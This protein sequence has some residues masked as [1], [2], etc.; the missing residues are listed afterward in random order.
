[1]TE[2]MN[3]K[4]V[5]TGAA[6]FIGSNVARALNA[7]GYK[8]LILVDRSF[9][10]EK[11]KNISDLIYSQKLT[12]DEFSNLTKSD[13]VRLEAII[14]IGASVDTT[15]KD[16]AGLIKNNTEYSRV[17]FDYCV[18]NNSRLIY[19]SSAATYGGGEKGYDDRERNLK[20][21]NPYAESKYLFDEYAQ[22]ALQKPAQWVGLKF[23]NVYGPGEA[24]KG[25][26]ASMVYHLY[27]K[28]KATGEAQIFKSYRPGIAHGEQKR[29]FVYVKDVA[30]VIL[31]FLRNP[32]K[33]GIF[34]L[35]TGEARSFNDMARAV[36]AALGKEPIIKYVDMPPGL[37][38][39]YQYFTRAD[40]SKL[41]SVGYGEKFYTLE[42]GVRDYVKNYLDK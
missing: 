24:H 19:A 1:M 5:I 36:F 9:D 38:A 12:A 2:R 18:R 35:G 40:I 34:N 8:D 10:G 41:R 25:Q 7:A 21:M 20:P 28:I 29:D 23:F 39:Q 17:L 15:D 33:S 37:D 32:E 6:G 4:I 22:D 27:H 31:F 42:E 14:H 11:A 30:K 3:N 26:M 13:F 16:R